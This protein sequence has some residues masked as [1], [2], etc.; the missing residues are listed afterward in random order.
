[1]I[2]TDV[3]LVLDVVSGEGG[4]VCGYYFASGSSRSVF[5]LDDMDIDMIAF[6]WGIPILS[7]A[8]LGASLICCI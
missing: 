8:H 4:V 7:H 3:E 6:R 2:Q 1:M 5:W